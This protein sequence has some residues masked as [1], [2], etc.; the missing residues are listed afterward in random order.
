METVTIF[1]CSE[2]WKDVRKL[3]KTV[4]PDI[5]E[6]ALNDEEFDKLSCMEKMECIPLLRQISTALRNKIDALHEI[7]NNHKNARHQ[8][9][10]SIDFVVWKLRWGVD[11]HGPAFGLRMMYSVK[12]KHV[13][14]A[15]IK[16]KKEIKDSE[17]NFQLET[18]ERLKFFFSYEYK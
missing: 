6:C 15:N 5:I 10:L 17:I 12:E 13:V 3:R 8:P 18:I 7:P 2:F 14:L 16:H 9:F 11:N 1:A 4:K